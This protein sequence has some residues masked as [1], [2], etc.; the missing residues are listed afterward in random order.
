MKKRELCTLVF[1][2]TLALLILGF[3]SNNF[4]VKQTQQRHDIWKQSGT[5]RSVSTTIFSTTSRV[6]YGK[7]GETSPVT[8]IATIV[9]V[10]GMK[11]IPKN[12]Q[13]LMMESTPPIPEIYS[14][15]ADIYEPISS[16]QKTKLSD[17]SERKQPIIRGQDIPFLW[18][19]ERTGVNTMSQVMGECLG[20]TLASSSDS[21]TGT[22]HRSFQQVFHDNSNSLR[23]VR[24]RNSKYINV[25]L[26]NLKGIQRASNLRILS[27]K[28]SV[29]SDQPLVQAVISPNVYDVTETLFTQ[30]AHHLTMNKGRLFTMIR[31]PVEREIS[32][33]YSL[34]NS[35]HHPL[36]NEALANYEISDWLKSKTFLDNIMVRSLV[37]NFDRGYE[38]TLDD[39]LISKEIMRRKCLVGLL[40][41][42]GLSWLRME[43]YFRRIWFNSQLKTSVSNDKSSS[44][45]NIASTHLQFIQSGQECKEK[46]LHLRWMNRNSYRPE[47]EHDLDLVSFYDYEREKNVKDSKFSTR[48][49]DRVS[50]ERV[51]MM[52]RYD[53]LLYEYAKYLFLE[54]GVQFDLNY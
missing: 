26:A 3:K 17:E 19:I 53:M 40:E 39:L 27:R 46:L 12:I 30:T 1:L 25:D 45:K 51:M 34:K 10:P 35:T 48:I 5:L 36:Y 18:H 7:I 23:T 24:H 13:Q 21:T 41:E 15:L 28:T 31:H 52:N 50:Y 29:G 20:L 16:P 9:N 8:W 37:R 14:N 22:R 4:Y 38:I 32:F 44:S 2:C 6:D 42:K 43:R 49:V 11:E 54:Q 47:V 33:F